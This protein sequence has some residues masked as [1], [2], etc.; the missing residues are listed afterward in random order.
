MVL[1]CGFQKRSSHIC[2]NE[3]KIEEIIIFHTIFFFVFFFSTLFFDLFFHLKWRLILK[4]NCDRCRNSYKHEKT[5]EKISSA[6]LRNNFHSRQ[7]CFSWI[8]SLPLF[9]SLT[10]CF[11][12]FKNIWNSEVKIEWNNYLRAKNK[13]CLN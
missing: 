5:K 4:G 6:L 1:K 13:F 2:E 12:K 9:V 3:N 10:N 8:F 7:T 11:T